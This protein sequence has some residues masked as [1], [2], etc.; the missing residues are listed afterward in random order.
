MENLE[1]VR[2]LLAT[3][4]R[5][6]ITTHHKPDGDAMGSS[7]GLYHYL[8]LKGHAVRVITPTDYGMFLHWLPGN[9]EVWEFPKRQA[10]SAAAVAEAEVIFC[11]DFNALHRIGALGDLVGAAP[12]PKVMIDHH[13]EP[14]NFDQFRLW[15]HTAAAT[16]EL[17]YDFIQRMGDGLLINKDISECLYTGIMTDTGSFR[18]TGT[19]AK[20][21]RTVAD[22]IDRGADNAAIHD[23][24]QDTSTENRLRFIGFCLSRKLKVLGKLNAA[25]IAVS[26]D[27]LQR[28]WIKTGDTEGLVNYPLSIEGV[29]LAALITER[30][31]ADEHGVD[32]LVV[33]LSLRSKGEFPAN[34]MA[35]QF[36]NGGGHRNA[37]GG[38]SDV[39]LYETIDLFVAACNKY[40]TLL[41]Q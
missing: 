36:F 14:E 41:G 9:A 20:I 6:V 33:K 17:I 34:D 29:K 18:H 11:L 7:L 30:K 3:P 31:E 19:T 22:L 5:I 28:Y 1:G 40:K 23:R 25:Y 32:R 27:E 15:E 21:H 12:A 10:E 2:E 37:A 24:V 35:A 39:G 13:L 26:W 38:R 4:K 8:T 16:C